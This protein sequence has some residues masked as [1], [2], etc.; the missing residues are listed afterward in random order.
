MESTST[1]ASADTKQPKDHMAECVL[2]EV[3]LLKADNDKIFAG[4]EWWIKVNGKVGLPLDMLCH[5]QFGGKHGTAC[6]CDAGLSVFLT[7]PTAEERRQ[8]CP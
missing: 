7:L 1:T 6:R 4:L 8:P 2:W 5:P 3:R